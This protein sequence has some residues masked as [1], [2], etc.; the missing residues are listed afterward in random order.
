[1]SSRPPG[2][3]EPGMKIGLFDHIE[4][5]ERPLAQLFDER[6][7]FIKAADET[8]FYCLHL[9][10][11]HQTPLNMVPVPGVFLGAVARATTRIKMGPLVYLLPIVSP[12]RLIDEICML[13]HLSKGRMEVGV[14]RG[15]SPFELR[16][17]KVE[18]DQSREIF[19]DAYECLRAGLQADQ[20]TYKGPHYRFENVPVALKPY[21]KPYPPFWYG[22]SGAEGSTWAGEQGM[23]FVTLGPNA[24]AKANIDSFRA[25]FAKHGKPL[26][27]KPEFSGGVAIGVQRHIFV[28]ETDEKAKAWA[29]PAMEVHLKNINW[30]RA[31][32]GV[33]ATQA[34]MKNVRGQNFEE[35][36][37]EGTV[38]AGS[39]ATVLREIEKQCAEIGFNYL[40]TYLFLGTM[41]MNDAMRS[42]KLF[43][44]DVMPKVERM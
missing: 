9:A 10:E 37:E 28:D 4:D 44:S 43:V 2:A 17:H 34:R 7:S 22:S 35:C 42:L 25:A 12:L 41:S 1:M 27:P 18:H 16:Y 26:N 32:H 39:P 8:G 6:L 31:R 20:L 11:H 38:I 14:G 13:D 21:Q 19:I 29:K 33:T 24:F 5:G 23:H 30:L 15:V 36:V 3:A 40:L